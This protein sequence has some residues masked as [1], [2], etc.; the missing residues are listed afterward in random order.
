[1][2][3][4]KR[5]SIPPGFWDLPPVRD[6][7][8]R[9]DLGYLLEL[10]TGHC[11]MSQ[12]A[13]AAMAG[14][15]QP[16]LWGYIRHS[17]K[18]TLDTIA[19]VAD[20]L[21]VPPHARVRLGLARAAGTAGPRV[22][23]SQVLVLAEH[24]GRTDDIS[25]L[26]A[27]R[28]AARAGKPEDT[29]A[30]LARVTH[31]DAPEELRAAERMSVRTRGFFLAAAKLPARLVIEALTYHVNDIGL[32]LDAIPDPG[33][34]R[35]LAKASGE[36]SYLVACCD[37]DLGDLPGALSG[38]EVTAAIAR[39]TGDAA[40]TAITL[41]GHS[42][43]RAFTG[44]H[45]EA[46]ALV[47]QGLDA[48]MTSGPPGTVTHMRLRAAEELI[49]LGQTSRAVEMWEQAEASYAATD[50]S[51]DRNWIR[52]WLSP[53]CFDSVKAVI[54]ASTGRTADAVP[55]ARGIASRL[56]G[57]LGKSDAVALIN[58]A[59]ALATA[60]RPAE[61]AGTARQALQAARAAEATGCMPRAH[62]V[63]EM[64]RQHGKPAS[65]VRRLI[66]ELEATQ[67][68]LDGLQARNTAM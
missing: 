38:L 14:M 68:Q 3:A 35:E 40:L 25:G 52:L 41:D 44:D 34:R 20:R 43:F 45:R 39:E 46:L 7:L 1:M 6:A 51:T 26:D 37:V 65:S 29:W 64:I 60:G 56:A 66:D 42:H 63:G 48:A 2:P 49:N 24:I 17:H 50:L 12:H 53:D 36:A 21:G 9:Q 10:V 61:A 5:R 23:L 18:P 67:R 59:L 58:A 54:Y 15:P 4:D 55:I 27:W 32:L 16:Q 13:V 31:V 8:D 30:R 57:A 19:R 62:A 28:E 33:P 22:R 47:G 11:G